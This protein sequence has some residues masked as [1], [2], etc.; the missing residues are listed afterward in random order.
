MFSWSET[1]ALTQQRCESVTEEEEEEEA[2]CAVKQ[3]TLLQD[4]NNNNNYNV[5]LLETCGT[6]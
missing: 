4:N 6:T 1:A 3:I 2:L 5:Y